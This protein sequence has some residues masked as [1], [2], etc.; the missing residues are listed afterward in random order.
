MVKAFIVKSIPL[1]ILNLEFC[2]DSVKKEEAQASPNPD[3]QNKK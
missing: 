1:F 2:P 3:T